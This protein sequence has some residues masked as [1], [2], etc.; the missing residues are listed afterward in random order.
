MLTS[1]CPLVPHGNPPFHAPLHLVHAPTPPTPTPPS[2]RCDT[3]L[4][5]A[6]GSPTCRL[7]R[8]VPRRVKSEDA[9]LP[10]RLRARPAGAPLRP[11]P[12]HSSLS[13]TVAFLHSNSVRPSSS[14]SSSS[15]QLCFSLPSV[16]LGCGQMTKVRHG[17][18]L[19]TFLS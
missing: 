4:G 3:R 9:K 2:G 18:H 6:M 13:F 7:C 1:V 5:R 15:L 10:R 19:H 14:R 11:P 8:Q 17:C 12:R 16:M